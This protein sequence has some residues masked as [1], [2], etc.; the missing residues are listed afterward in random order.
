ME[1]NVWSNPK[2]KKIL[3]D[4]YIV[5]ALY[6]D[7]KTYLPKESW[8]TSSYDNKIKKTIGKQNFDLQLTN[9]NSNA[10]PY[11][12]LLDHNEKLLVDPRAYNLNIDQFVEFLKDGLEEFYK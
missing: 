8:Y 9:F 5:V 11:Y 10:Q 3:D 1:E 4:N 6:V 2:V 12:V 7:D